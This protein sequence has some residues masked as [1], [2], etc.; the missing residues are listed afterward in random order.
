MQIGAD[1]RIA[2]IA[3]GS[4][5]WKGNWALLLKP[6]SSTS[7]ATRPVKPG[8]EPHTGSASAAV[9]SVVPVRTTM[10]PTALTSVNPPMNVMSSVRIEAASPACPERATRKNDARLV[11]S[12]QMKSSTRSSA[13][14]SPTIDRV[15][16]AM[17]R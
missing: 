9:R 1:R 16:V 5:T 10:S 11:S 7:T 4:Q 13:S 6:A 2:A 8:S 17:T 3:S 14:T 15:N 12:Q